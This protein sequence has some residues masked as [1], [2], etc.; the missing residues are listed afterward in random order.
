MRKRR[1]IILGILVLGLLLTVS[2]VSINSSQ[3]QKFED[4]PTETANDIFQSEEQADTE[5][6]FSDSEPNN[7]QNNEATKHSEDSKDSSNTH[8]SCGCAWNSKQP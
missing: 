7:Q 2:L 8:F 4:N 5:V 3:K 6:E 1:N